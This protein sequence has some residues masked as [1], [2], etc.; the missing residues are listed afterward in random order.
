M[1]TQITDPAQDIYG[2][3]FYAWSR[4]RAELLRARRFSDLDLARL[5]EEVE[6]LGE[7]VY[8]SVRFRVRTIVLGWS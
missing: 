2:Q 7:T 5:A 3:D 8:R 4:R 1:P 6:D